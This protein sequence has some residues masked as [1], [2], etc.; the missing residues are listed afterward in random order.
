[1]HWLPIPKIIHQNGPNQKVLLY[2]GLAELTGE[3]GSV[4]GVGQI[5]LSWYPS[6]LI[7]FSLTYSGEGRIDLGSNLFLK[8]SDLVPQQRVNVKA[9]TYTFGGTGQNHIVGCLTKPHIIGNSEGLSCITFHITN[10]WFFNI[11]NDWESGLEQE[12]WLDFDGQLVFDYKDWHIVLGNLHGNY[13]LIEKLEKKGG[14][15]ITHICKLEKQ[16]RSSFDLNE[17][18]DFV[19]AFCCYL[20]FSRGFWTAPVLVSGYDDDGKLMM[21]EWGSRLSQA[22]AWQPS[23]SWT[24]NCLDSLEIVDT[25]FGFMEKWNDLAW[26]QVIKDCVQWF[27]EGSYQNRTL[28]TSIIVFQASLEQLSWTYF[29]NNGCLSA[30]GFNSLKAGDK[31]RLLV[32]FLD[33]PI[34]SLDNYPDLKEKSK[35][36]NWIDS[37]DALMK[38]RNS[39]IHP[40]TRKKG[41]SVTNEVLKELDSLSHLYLMNILLKLSGYP[42]QL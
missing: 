26:K 39:I 13:D 31:F 28:K 10:F 17:A 27:I 32:S 6:P 25:F 29:N 38:V 5:T 4:E 40:M 16:D 42:Y 8:L 2:K 22:D 30:D 37:L 1:M 18:Y 36:L 12:F 24:Y 9:S 15:G 21:E 3:D 41:Y 35:E 23:R 14:Y 33:V 11:S 7:E 34:I 20:S 19:E